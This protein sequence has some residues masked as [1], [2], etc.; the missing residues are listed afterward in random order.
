MKENKNLIYLFKEYY[1]FDC[2]YTLKADYKNDKNSIKY[3]G[4]FCPKCGKP[5]R[6]NEVKR[7]E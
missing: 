2:K 3:G 6:N 1:C 5:I 4:V 7:R